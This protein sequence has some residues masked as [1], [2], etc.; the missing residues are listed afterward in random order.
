VY[1]EGRLRRLI[2]KSALLQ[3]EIESSRASKDKY[4]TEWRRH[5]LDAAVREIAWLQDMINT[6]KKSS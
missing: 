3:A 1:S 5:S 4:L 6:E 2:E